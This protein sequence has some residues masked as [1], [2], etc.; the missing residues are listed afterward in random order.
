MRIEAEGISEFDAWSRFERSKESSGVSHKSIF[1]GHDVK[2][3]FS[4]KNV[5]HHRFS[6]D[7]RMK[8]IFL[9]SRNHE[10][11]AGRVDTGFSVGGSVTWGGKEGPK[12]EVTVSATVRDK[13]SKTHADVK[14]KVDSDGEQTVSA[15]GGKDA[16]ESSDS[17][18]SVDN[19]GQDLR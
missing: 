8:T 16:K 9:G 12:A 2:L 6:D 1:S 5:A 3:S 4:G 17:G 10:I 11:I 14:Y 13:E 15:D 7:P 19:T 18:T